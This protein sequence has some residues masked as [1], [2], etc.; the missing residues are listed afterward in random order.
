MSPRFQSPLRCDFDSAH[1]LAHLI[2]KATAV[3]FRE[4][5]ALKK[6]SQSWLRTSRT[7]TGTRNP[8]LIVLLIFYG[9]VARSVR[10]VILIGA[11]ARLLG[12]RGDHS[13]LP[14]FCGVDPSTRWP[15][16]LE[17]PGLGNGI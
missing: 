2:E 3:R 14:H 7:Q 9:V 4:I 6:C 16:A 17:S 13:D 11:I 12:R 1:M 8:P 10:Y 15:G 5:D